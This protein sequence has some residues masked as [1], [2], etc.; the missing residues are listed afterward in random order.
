MTRFDKS[1]KDRIST[2]RPL[3]SSLPFFNH[4]K[5]IFSPEAGVQVALTLLPIMESVGKENDWIFKEFPPKKIQ[6]FFLLKK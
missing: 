3:E 4:L 6:T 5:L 2:L 1:E